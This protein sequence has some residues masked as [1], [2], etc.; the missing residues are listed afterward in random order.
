MLLRIIGHVDL[1]ETVDHKFARYSM[2]NASGRGGPL[3]TPPLPKK[4]GDCRRANQ[5]TADSTHAATCCGAQKHLCL[6]FQTLFFGG[7]TQIS[8]HGQVVNL[9][10]LAHHGARAA[11]DA[12]EQTVLHGFHHTI[13]LV[14]WI[15]VA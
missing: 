12:F 2:R 7:R 10:R 5:A 15:V 8:P 6:G 9:Q 3:S 14:K 4:G 1:L 13:P 11:F